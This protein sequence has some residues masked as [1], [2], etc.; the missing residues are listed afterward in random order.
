MCQEHQLPR[1]ARNE[2]VREGD[3]RPGPAR[4]FNFHAERFPLMKAINGFKTMGS[5]PSTLRDC[6][7]SPGH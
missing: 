5:G 4:D 3:S 6:V 2:Y 7:L 1:S